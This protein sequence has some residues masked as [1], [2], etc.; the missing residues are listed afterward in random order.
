MRQPKHILSANDNAPI[1]QKRPRHR[2]TPTRINP[3]VAPRPS[4]PAHHILTE[5]RR[6]SYVGWISP[7]I[8]FFIAGYAIFQNASLGSLIWPSA[9][10]GA[11]LVWTATRAEFESR[12]RNIACLMAVGAIAVCFAGMMA[13]NGLTLIAVEITLMVSAVSL[14]IG[15]M[16]N[17]RSATML[18]V[19]ATLA[20]LASLFTSLGIFDGLVDGVSQLGKG[21][22]PALLIGQI[23]LAHRLK[24]RSVTF[25]AIIGSYIWMTTISTDIPTTA[26]AGIGF[27][28]AAAH[29]CLGKA[30]E[31]RALFG[32][33]LHSGL[34]A[35]LGLVCAFYIQSV[36][37]SG[38]TGQAS[39]FWPPNTLWMAAL[40]TTVLALFV[41]SIM[42]YKDSQISL[43]GIFIISFAAT[44]LPLA[45]AKPDILYAAFDHVPGL[46]ANPGFG[47]VI[48]ALIIAFGLSYIVNGLRG[49]HFFGV[50]I[51]AVAIGMQGLILYAPE[52]L[53]IDFGVIFLGS[54]VFALCV[55]GLIAG[56]TTDYNMPRPERA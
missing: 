51:G 15:W 10:M 16:F 4:T 50:L 44:I 6:Q 25:A 5:H 34:A 26:K 18:S 17:S 27:A 40:M 41:S 52:R 45:T 48:G 23:L 19:L 32:A 14:I 8:A 3:K 39:P 55:G 13:H 11:A 2:T 56:S 29:Y 54:L 43:I 42:R 35:L 47:L 24:S 1:K 36:W 20:Y 28:L 30:G 49:G 12:L 46:D 31:S 21:L 38:E 9:M 37:I 53:N 22:I 33:K 7:I